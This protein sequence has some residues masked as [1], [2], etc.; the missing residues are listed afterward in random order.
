MKK[1]KI[2]KIIKSIINEGYCVLGFA[3]VS[4]GG[5]LLSLFQGISVTAVLTLYRRSAD[6]FI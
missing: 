4:G 1:F 5:D 3:K 2:I 6:R